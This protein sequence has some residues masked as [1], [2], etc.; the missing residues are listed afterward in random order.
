MRNPKTCFIK[1]GFSFNLCHQP[2]RILLVQKYLKMEVKA[3]EIKIK[4]M[5]KHLPSSLAR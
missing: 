1:D 2:Y 5:R 4:Q 3:I